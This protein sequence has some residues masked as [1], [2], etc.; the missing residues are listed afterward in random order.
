MR[1]SGPFPFRLSC[2]DDTVRSPEET[3]QRGIQP[4][5]RGDAKPLKKV[6]QRTYARL[7]DPYLLGL[8]QSLVTG[9]PTV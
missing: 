4:S 6:R 3:N 2:G 9:W 5:C 7:R 8:R 1:E